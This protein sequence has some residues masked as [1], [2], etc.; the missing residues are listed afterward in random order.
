MVPF[1]Q[2]ASSQNEQFWAYYHR[3]NSEEKKLY[4]VIYDAIVAVKKS[5][6]FTGNFPDNVYRRVFNGVYYDHPELFW[7]TDGFECTLTDYGNGTQK[8][9]MFFDYTSLAWNLDEKIAQL[10]NLN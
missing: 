9:E 4:K 6:V 7:I 5:V 1:L 10:Y 8:A 3:L 2:S